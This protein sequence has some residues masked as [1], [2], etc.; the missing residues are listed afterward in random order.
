MLLEVL[1]R[2]GAM[3]AD[4]RER[5]IAGMLEALRQC[6]PRDMEE[7]TLWTDDT[8]RA[9]GTAIPSAQFSEER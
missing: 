3:T 6:K 9:D 4:Q 2:V 8:A 5:E 1:P 7:L